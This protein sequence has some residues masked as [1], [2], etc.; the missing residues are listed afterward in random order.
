VAEAGEPTVKDTW[1]RLRSR[2][3]VQ[4]GLAYVAVSW[5]LVQGIAFAVGTF[6]WHELMTR[7]AA[8]LA[9]AGVPVV[10]TIAW[11]H[12]DRGEQRI[13]RTEVAVLA[14]VLAFAAYAVVREAREPPAAV[15]L[16]QDRGSGRPMRA[17]DRRRIAILPFDNLGGIA[18]NAAFVGGVHDTLIT[19]IA[20]IPGLSVIARS[21]VLQFAGR[22]PTIREVAEALAVGT[23]LEGSVEREGDSLRIQAQLIDARTDA[24]LWAETYDRS[25][26]DLFAVQSEIAQAVAEQLRIRLTGDENRRRKTALSSNPEAYEHYVLGRNFAGQWKWPEAIRE[27]TAAVTLDPRFAEAYAYLSLARTWQGFMDPQQRIENVPLALDAANKALALDPTLPEGHLALAVYF[28]R[29]KPDIDRAAAEFEHALTGLPNDAVAYLNFSFLRRWQGRW[30]E[31]SAL[32]G[33]AAELD[34]YG[35]APRN[36]IWNLVHQ[37][38]RDEA[39]RAVAAVISAQPGNAELALW[40]GELARIFSCDLATAERIFRE[41]ALRFPDSSDVLQAQINFALQTGDTGTAMI[42]LGRLSSGVDVAQPEAS[43]LRALTYRAAGRLGESDEWIRRYLQAA[44]R[45]FQGLPPSALH[46]DDYAWIAAHY[47]LLGDRKLALEYVSRATEALPPTGDAGNRTDA[48]YFT[49][50][51]LAWANEPRRAVAQLRTLLDSP[52]WA[53]PAYL[54]CDPYLAPLRRH[55]EFR[56]LLAAHGADVSIDPLRRETWPKH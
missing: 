50:I 25:A 38:R 46:S 35:L 39:A 22:H 55:P 40:P 36:Y 10:I 43:W 16:A 26:K 33:R 23:V 3:V 19:Q 44:Q 48:L 15:E 49:A 2:K 29:G 32:S 13:T 24:H 1:R 12:G 5:G 53:K 18:A 34:P 28:Y 14:F 47:A 56:Q 20:K 52:S 41:V 7:I 51:A 37:G 8:V 6:H 45:E 4:W 31:A 21:S 27:F 54:W 30:E 17:L 42:L 11:F 9:V